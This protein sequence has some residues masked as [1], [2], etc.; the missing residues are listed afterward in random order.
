MTS[1]PVELRRTDQRELW[2]L[3]DDGQEQ[4]IP[5]FRLR[6]A[7]PCATC[8]EKEAAEPKRPAT[9]LP[10]ISAAEAQPV[11]IVAMRAVGNYGYNIAFSDGHD[12]GIFTL[13]YLRGM[14]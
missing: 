13:E 9:L 5:F 1:V 6:K 3:W 11:Q 14:S 12:S 8:R 10:V 4:R 7:C 2:I